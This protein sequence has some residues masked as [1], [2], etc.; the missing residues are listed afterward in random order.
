MCRPPDLRILTH[1]MPELIEAALEAEEEALDEAEAT[2]R[3]GAQMR[4]LKQAPCR[5]WPYPTHQPGGQTAQ[6]ELCSVPAT[7]QGRC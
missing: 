4:R 7:H 5:R 2:V 3:E 6:R 1:A